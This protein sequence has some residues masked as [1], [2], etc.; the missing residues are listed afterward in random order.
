ELTGRFQSVVV[1][2][3]ESEDLVLIPQRGFEALGVDCPKAKLELLAKECQQSPSLM[4]QFCWNIC[5]EMNISTPERPAK[6]VPRN[7]DYDEMFERISRD[8]G[9]PVYRKLI[10]GPQQR[11]DRMLRPLR[12]GG[13]ADVYEAT[14]AAIAHTGP[15]PV[16][17]YNELRSS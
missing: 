2:E 3:W 4:Q 10:A 6:K 9:L 14:L 15:R 16:L 17:S 11:R 7:F 1:P 12:S 8:A 5:Y 13:E